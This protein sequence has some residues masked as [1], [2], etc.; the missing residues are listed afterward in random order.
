MKAPKIV[1]TNDDG[2]FSPGLRILYEA[3]RDLGEVYIVSPIFPKSA[4][5]LGLTLHKPIR[6]EEHSMGGTRIY[7]IN[8]TP[9]D[10]V[11]VAREVVVKEIDLLVSGINIG[12]NTS[13]QTILASGTVGAAA[14]AALMGIPAIA[15]SADVSEAKEMERE[16]YREFLIEGVKNVV[17][18]VLEK[19]F[20][21]N[22]DVINVN[23]PKE[24]SGVVRVVPAARI[25]WLEKLEKRVDPRGMEYY[26]LYGTPAEPEENTDVYVIKKEKGIAITPLVLDMSAT[27][28]K[29]YSELSYMADYLRK[30]LGERSDD[31]R[32]FIA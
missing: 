19:G 17:K 32:R 18:Y 6:I 9:S 12:D 26:W 13:M 24:F 7:G 20:P 8:G 16:G 4:V 31:R 5:G 14:E 10:A 22:T 30:N 27:T 15:F 29:A 11:H 1:V 28:G 2:I 25:R 3:V 21:Q 23:F